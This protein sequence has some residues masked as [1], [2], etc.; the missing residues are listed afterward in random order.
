[1]AP[2]KRQ[3]S[4]EGAVSADPPPRTG[5]RREEV[6][7]LGGIIVFRSRGVSRGRPRQD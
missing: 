2:F 5:F 3:C 1:M 7:T 6:K 4:I